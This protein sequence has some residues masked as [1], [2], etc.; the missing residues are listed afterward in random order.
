MP[1]KS[2]AVRESVGV[3]LSGSDKGRYML[4]VQGSKTLGYLKARSPTAITRLLLTDAGTALQYD[5]L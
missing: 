1:E 5:S 4:C 3:P 2:H